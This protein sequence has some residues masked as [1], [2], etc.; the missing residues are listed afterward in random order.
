MNW[1]LHPSIAERSTWEYWAAIA[2]VAALV[3]SV[4]GFAIRVLATSVRRRDASNENDTSSRQSVVLNDIAQQPISTAHAQVPVHVEVNQTLTLSDTYAPHPA[5]SPE[6]PSISSRPRHTAP[7]TPHIPSKTP[8]S[9]ASLGGL[10][11]PGPRPIRKEGEIQAE[12]I[13]A[14][15]VTP[16]SRSAAPSLSQQILPAEDRERA[17][18]SRSVIS[19]AD[20]SSVV[21]PEPAEGL[22][23]PIPPSVQQAPASGKLPP[24]LLK[25]RKHIRTALWNA[26]YIVQALGDMTKKRRETGNLEDQPYRSYVRAHKLLADY[27]AAT[28]DAVAD[29]NTSLNNLTGINWSNGDP[30]DVFFA[31][32]DPIASSAQQHYAAIRKRYYGALVNMVRTV[33]EMGYTVR[34]RPVS[35][36]RGFSSRKWEY[37]L[38]RTRNPQLE[39][40]DVLDDESGDAEDTAE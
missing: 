22:S 3:A 18:V 32:L 36:N 12:G 2:T 21:T 31:N 38:T 34:R 10:T 7:Q 14:V 40:F 4:L 28:K 16:S 26:S 23:T 13:P 24:H 33:E 25:Q 30:R 6:V 17:R 37:H 9:S 35:D 8:I 19:E 20:E 39:T 27:L 29:L 11:T 5:I 15:P 1:L